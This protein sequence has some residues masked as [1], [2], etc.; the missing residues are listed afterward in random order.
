MSTR[1]F[2]S[3]LYT[4][5]FFFFFLNSFLWF[6]GFVVNNMAMVLILTLLTDDKY[7]ISNGYFFVKFLF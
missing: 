4:V 1:Y 5:A 6:L 7:I 3:H 2:P